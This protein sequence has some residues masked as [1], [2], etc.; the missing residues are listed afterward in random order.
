VQV[1]GKRRDEIAVPREADKATIEQLA[2]A[3][4]TVQKHLEGKAPKQITTPEYAAVANYAYHLDAGAFAELLREHATAHLGVT[5]LQREV[6]RAKL[7]EDGGIAA[8]CTEEGEDVEADLFVDCTGMRALLLGEALGSPLTDVSSV[9]F[10]DR[11]LAIQVPYRSEEEPIASQTNATAVAA[12]WIWDIGLTTRRGVGHV[13]SS[14]FSSEKEARAQLGHYLER[15][16]PGTGAKAEDARLIPFRSAYREEAWRANCV[17]VG[18]AQGFVAPLEASAIVMAELSAAMISDLLPPRACLMP[19]AAERFNARFSYRWERIVAFLKLH[20]IVSKRS[21]PY[22]EA[23]RDEASWT[24]RLR[25][26]MERW[27]HEPPS[28]EDFPQTQEI[29]TAASYAYVLYGS[30]FATQAPAHRRRRDAP[31]AA[32]RAAAEIEIA[33]R[34]LLKGLPSNR[35]LVQHIM[36]RGLSRV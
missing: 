3:S 8:L 5:H 4:E 2:L 12:G 28:R 20:Y 22:W 25:A 15:T 26:L 7:R 27:R 32:Q 34:R 14:A 21:E 19:A 29:F 17:G 13:F 36:A 16:A 31:E 24:P 1:N 30:G 35:Q 18:M 10:N 6:V 33:R 9:L 11:A 23:H